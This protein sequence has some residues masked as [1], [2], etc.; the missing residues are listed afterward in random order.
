MHEMQMLQ[1]YYASNNM[2]ELLTYTFHLTDKLAEHIR[3]NYSMSMR[4]SMDVAAEAAE[5]F[6]HRLEQ[7]SLAVTAVYR[8]LQSRARSIILSR[9]K[10]SNI[11]NYQ[12]LA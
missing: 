9:R 2:T 6:C 7:R 5:W 1:R 10:Q 4:N 8:A 3:L 12:H 11:G